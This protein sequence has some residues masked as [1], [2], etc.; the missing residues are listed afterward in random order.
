MDK[1]KIIISNNLT[2]ALQQ[3][4]AGCPHDKL[5][6]LLDTT[7]E[8][9]CW[10]LMRDLDCMAGAQTITIGDTD[11]H[12][13]IESLGQVWTAL[14]QGGATRHSLLVNVVLPPL[15]SSGAS[16]SSIFPPPCWPW[17]TPR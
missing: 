4:L 12:K 11:T 1:Q 2:A 16:A 3:A 9:L 13:T 14:G 15:P 5:F 10:P 7:T 17:L 6:V 8:R